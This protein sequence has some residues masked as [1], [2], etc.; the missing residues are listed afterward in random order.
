MK[1]TY[2]FP[3]PLQL[4]WIGSKEASFNDAYGIMEET[5]IFFYGGEIH[6]LTYAFDV[7][8][9]VGFKDPSQVVI[10]PITE[11]QI[12]ERL[13]GLAISEQN[14]P[15]PFSIKKAN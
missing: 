14:I 11:L 1:T 8:N 4:T 7:V 5:Q 2:S 3:E 12:F 6:E 10:P 15:F 13:I 9:H